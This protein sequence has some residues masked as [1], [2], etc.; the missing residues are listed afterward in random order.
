MDPMDPMLI[1]RS[2]FAFAT[3]GCSHNSCAVELPRGASSHFVYDV[4]NSVNLVFIEPMFP[5]MAAKME[6]IGD[7]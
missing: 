4:P 1:L 7:K 5:M 2:A 6:V 3:F